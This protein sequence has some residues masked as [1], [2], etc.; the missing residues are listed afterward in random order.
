MRAL[1][2]I[3]Y[4]LQRL[5]RIGDDFLGSSM[6]TS[7]SLLMYTLRALYTGLRCEGKEKMAVR[8]KGI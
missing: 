3:F 8:R 4:V 7:R 1:V 5:S 2:V 6:L